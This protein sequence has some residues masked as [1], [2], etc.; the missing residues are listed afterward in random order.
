MLG[1]DNETYSASVEIYEMI[2]W[3][4][5]VAWVMVSP[6]MIIERYLLLLFISLL[7]LQVASTRDVN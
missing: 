5:L 2:F 3:R 1:T 4:L 6:D 7:D